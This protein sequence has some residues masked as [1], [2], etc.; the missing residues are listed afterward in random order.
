MN[1]LK[2]WSAGKGG[3]INLVRNKL[4][5]LISYILKK[6]YWIIWEFFPNGGPTFELNQFGYRTGL[7]QLSQVFKG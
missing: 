1:G 2:F 3:Q 7:S 5:K 4:S 6:N